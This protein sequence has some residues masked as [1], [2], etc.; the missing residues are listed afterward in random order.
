MKHLSFLVYCTHP[1]FQFTK[2][3]DFFLDICGFVPPF[4][5]TASGSWLHIFR[6]DLAVPIPSLFIS[7]EITAIAIKAVG[8]PTWN[9]ITRFIYNCYFSFRFPISSLPGGGE[10]DSG[11]SLGLVGSGG[12]SS[13][14]GAPFLFSHCCYNSSFGQCDTPLEAVWQQAVLDFQ[15]NRRALESDLKCH[16]SSE[17]ITS[18][19]RQ[20]GTELGFVTRL[21]ESLSIPT[22]DIKVCHNHAVAYRR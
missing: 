10:V 14:Q 2:K 11:A 20:M 1:S 6:G 21:A 13:F 4:Q 16:R 9:E 17:R 22:A 5:K 12:S 18:S 3:R 15:F 7:M 8:N 19:S